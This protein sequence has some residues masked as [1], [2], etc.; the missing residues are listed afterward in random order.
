MACAGK[1]KRLLTCFTDDIRRRDSWIGGKKDYSFSLCR[2]EDIMINQCGYCKREEMQ[3][4]GAH[5]G[6]TC[7][8]PH[9]SNV[10]KLLL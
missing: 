10:N 4:P 8:L 1:E 9:E 5:N 6:P 2:S 7:E 3:S